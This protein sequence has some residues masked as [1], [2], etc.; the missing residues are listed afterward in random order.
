MNESCVL[1]QTPVALKKSYRDQDN[2]FCCAGCQAVYQILFTKQALENYKTHPLFQQALKSGLIANPLLL[3]EVRLSQEMESTEEEV[4]KLHLEIQD[5]WCPSCAMV[6]RLILLR[7]KGIRKCAVDYA[8]DLASIEYCP[9][10]ISSDRILRIIKKLGYSP[11]FLQDPR[12]EKVSRS[13]SLRFTIGAF[14]SVNIMMFAYPIYASYFYDDMEG[15]PEL[16]GWLSLLGS[17]PVLTYS[18]WPIWRRFYTAL[19]VGIWGMEALVFIGVLAATGLSIYELL[20]GSPYVYFDSMTVIIVFVLLGKIIESKAKFSAKDSLVKLMRALPRRGRKRFDNG[21][22]R[23]V[24]L[25]EIE[26]N[27]IIVVMNGEKIVLDG[28]VI[29]GEG[30]CDESLMTG[31]SLPTLKKM[32][33]QVLA[34]T[35]L[36]QGYLIIKVTATREETALY[37]II[38]MVEQ[39]IEHKSNYVRAADKVVKWFVP[40]VIL[41]ALF[42]AGYCL[43]FSIQDG[44]QTVMQT[45]IIRAV[46]VLLISCPCAIGIAAPLAESYVLNAIAKLGAIVRN[47][48]CLPF[49]GKETVF[50]FDKTGTITEGK[51][52]VISGTENLTFEQKK[53][54]KGLSAR[55]IHP[56]ATAINTS[57]LCPAANFNSIEEVIGMGMKGLIENV[58]FL[59]GS[60]DFL[61]AQGV[62][63]ESMDNKISESVQSHVYF[64]MDGQ[65]LTSISLGDRIRK[66]AINL[67]QSLGH[68]KTLLVSGDSKETVEAVAKACQFDEWHF[69][70]HP[71]QKRELVDTLRKNG[72]IVAVMG[73]G[74]NDAPALTSAHIGIA[75][76]SATDISIQVSDLLLTTDKLQTI[77]TL[78]EIAIKGRTIIK[79]NLFWAFFYNCIGIGLAMAG[80]LSP[81]FA[82]FAMIISSVVVLFNAQRVG[83]S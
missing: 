77:I 46:S 19:R 27:E 68:V 71:L 75:V 83:T 32:G 82:A 52:V 41:L 13:L 65:C 24:S 12:Q 36:Q 25:K 7:E 54:L 74:I 58:V 64:A 76:V 22:E 57:L 28:T 9:Q 81:L 80:V 1:C 6:I 69:S 53:C 44:S 16:F 21:E 33:S 73:D 61:R 43:L 5:M 3:E 47:R 67:L 50:V 34:G 18:G 55:S 48:G 40:I 59:L 56:I 31:E 17:I 70:C 49:L 38:E 79:Q 20:Q 29:E 2:V 30:A 51:F 45:A 4:Q 39:D 66:D 23:F 63:F 37:K 62:L 26:P 14:F 72:E 60:K 78:R 35:I 15:Y 11:S 42:T 8:T 10:L